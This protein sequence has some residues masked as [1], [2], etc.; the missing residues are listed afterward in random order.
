[1]AVKLLK[2]VEMTEVINHYFFSI[3]G[4]KKNIQKE[5]DAG[6]WKCKDDK[7][8]FDPAVIWEDF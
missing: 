5:N 6:V 1:M 4:K 8:L 2:N 7:T 3:F